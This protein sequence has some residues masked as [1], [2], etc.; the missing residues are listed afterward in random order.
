MPLERSRAEFQI[1]GFLM[2]KSTLRQVASQE[3]SEGERVR[4]SEREGERKRKGGKE[5]GRK[6]K[7]EGKRESEDENINENES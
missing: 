7:R 2:P 1:Q 6:G 5:E 4:V 3:K